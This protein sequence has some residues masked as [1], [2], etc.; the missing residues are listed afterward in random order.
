MIDGCHF[1]SQCI[2]TFLTFPILNGTVIARGEIY[3]VKK[4]M[5][6]NQVKESRARTVNINTEF[7]NLGRFI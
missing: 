7:H 2:D 6:M 5:K 3:D 1:H 4:L